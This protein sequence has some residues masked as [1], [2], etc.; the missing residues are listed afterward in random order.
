MEISSSWKKTP[1]TQHT[2][3]KLILIFYRDNSSLRSGVFACTKRL[4]ILTSHYNYS[5]FF[6][7]SAG[8]FHFQMP[9]NANHIIFISTEAVR[10]AITELTWAWVLLLDL[11]S[12][13]LALMILWNP[14]SFRNQ[15]L[16]T[17]I[18]VVAIMYSRILCSWYPCK[19]CAHGWCWCFVLCNWLCCLVLWVL[20][21]LA[22][23]WWFGAA[24][25]P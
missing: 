19:T 18:I 8:S 15:V 7:D 4:F 10:F 2:S 14:N 25:L 13:F 23:A 24:W 16:F 17:T 12:Q 20:S 21:D 3:W 1:H 6:P 9:W 5:S 22:F 11:V